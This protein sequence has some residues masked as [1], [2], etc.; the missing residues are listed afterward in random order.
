MTTPKFEDLPRIKTD[1]PGHRTYFN[2]TTE[3]VEAK[4]ADHQHDQPSKDEDDE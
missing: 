2:L 1:R 3:E 4:E